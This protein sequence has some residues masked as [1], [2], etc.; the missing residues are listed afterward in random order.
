MLPNS[1]FFPAHDLKLHLSLASFRK[2]NKS[3][4]L[5]EG[6][7]VLGGFGR[8]HLETESLVSFAAAREARLGREDAEV[9]GVL[10]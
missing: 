8:V 1:I 5:F 9:V 10:V 2:E 3:I 7:A 6:D 4:W